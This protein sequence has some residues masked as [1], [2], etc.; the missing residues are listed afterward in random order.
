MKRIF[1]L[2]IVLAGISYLIA[3]SSG[4]DNTPIAGDSPTESYKRLFNAVKAKDTKAIR[5]E[6]TKKTIE[7]GESTAKQFNKTLDEHFANGFTGTTFSD[8]LPPIRDE[9]I[10]GNM[11]A[12]EVYNAKEHTW[13]DLPFILED[14]R[15]RLA[16]G[17]NWAGGFQSP[18]KGRDQIEKEAANVLSPNVTVMTPNMSTNIKTNSQP[19]NTAK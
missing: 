8:T 10:K 18:G 4:P 11:G 17:D 2:T 13:E 6:M 5:Q 1:I 14:G 3:C 15:W 19:K 12:I 16:I 9:R 7:F